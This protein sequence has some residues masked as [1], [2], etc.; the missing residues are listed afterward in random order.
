MYYIVVKH[1][2]HVFVNVSVKRSNYEKMKQ[3]ME[4]EN[5]QDKNGFY[6]TI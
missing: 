2:G 6:L 4:Q 1:V 3:E 5:P